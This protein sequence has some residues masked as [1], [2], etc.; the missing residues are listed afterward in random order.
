MSRSWRTPAFRI[1]ALA[2]LLAAFSI[3]AMLLLTES[4]DSRFNK[5]TAAAQGG[6]LVL[7]G[8][9]PPSERQQQLLADFATAQ[10]VSFA[11]VLVHEEQFLLASVRA[12]SSGFPLYG[13]F[14]VTGQRF[15]TPRTVDQGPAPGHI[16]LAGTALDRLK[17]AV[18]DAITLGEQ[19][20]LIQ[21][22]I[23]QEPDQQ[24]GFYSM[25][26]RALIHQQDLQRTGVL[27][28]GSRY[29]HRVLVAAPK[30][31]DS[32]QAAI[33]PTLRPDQA[34]ETLADASLRDRGPVQQLFLWMQL[35]IMLV[36]L[37]CAAALYLTAAQRG[38]QQQRLCAVMKTLGASQRQVA[39]RILG[40]DILALVPPVIAG[41]GL[42]WLVLGLLPSELDLPLPEQPGLPLA[43]AMLAPALLWL[44][45]AAP[46]LWQLMALPP[47]R[48]L[49]SQDAASQGALRIR[50]IALATPVP[51]AWLL[52]GS[53]QQLWLLLALL[54]AVAVG[55]PLLLW[56]LV[57]GLEATSG[58][59]P[60]DLRLALRRLTRRQSITLPLL[61]ALILSLAVLSLSIQAGRELLADWRTTLPEDAPNYFVVNL[62]DDD[63]DSFQQWLK[64]QGQESRSLYPVSRARLTQINGEPVREA[65]SKEN[66]RQHESLNRDLSLT[67]ATALPQ[68]NTLSGG[69]WLE[70]TGDVSVESK[71]ADKLGIE[72]GDTLTFTGAGGQ[73]DAKVVGFREVDWESFSPNF[74]FMF[75]PGTLSALERTWLTSFYLPDQDAAQLNELVNRYPQ[76]SLLD[77]NALLDQLQQ[78]VSQASR[79]AQLVGLLMLLAAALVLL[80]ALLATAQQQRQDSRLLRIL[81]ARTARL[82]RINGLQALLLIGGAALLANLVHLAAL[83]P[84]GQ[85]LLDGQLPLSAWL[86]LPWALVVVLVVLAWCVPPL[87]Y[88]SGRRA[89]NR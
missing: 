3:A 10:T 15:G 19:R 20:F 16:W 41:V 71:V 64:E 78:L 88:S 32:L 52:A 63:L 40:R 77:V 22:V 33:E 1:Q 59:L 27:G 25:N 79:A 6:D 42:A 48:L 61:A 87:P 68:S 38:R 5:R 34:I 89:S 55:L 83:W 2:M 84:L 46:V 62:F 73:A 50:L 75:T 30:D 24:G 51:V 31:S 45:F 11:S 21:R 28:E 43:L 7:T 66:D 29:Q 58:K 56:P 69:R 47:V 36:V 53:L 14:T 82:R 17:L 49:G 39:Q 54:L 60:V 37:L 74:Y 26:P 70:D 18:G 57:R 35:A 65:V 12:V 81:G 67:E 86:L 13:E 44:G 72:L 8:S 4:V 76:I 80:A 85:K 9:Q 23:Q